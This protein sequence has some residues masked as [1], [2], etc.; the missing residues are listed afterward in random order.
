MA[1]KMLNVTEEEQLVTQIDARVSLPTV[2]HQRRATWRAHACRVHTAVRGTRGSEQT[3][4]GPRPRRAGSERCSPTLG[5][6]AVARPFFFPRVALWKCLFAPTGQ[7]CRAC[8]S[9][10][11]S[12]RS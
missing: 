9:W 6:G 3:E 12:E 8:G 2:I 7:M 1:L 4:L 10:A 11:P 5:A